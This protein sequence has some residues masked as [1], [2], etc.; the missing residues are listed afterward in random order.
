M[1]AKCLKLGPSSI[2]TKNAK[3]GTNTF[4]KVVSDE[5]SKTDAA[6]YMLKETKKQLEKK[7]PTVYDGTNQNLIPVPVQYDFGV[8]SSRGSQGANAKKKDQEV[9]RK[10]RA[11]A[12]Q[13]GDESLILQRIAQLEQLQKKKAEDEREK[14]HLELILR[15]KSPLS[16]EANVVLRFRTFF[17]NEPGLCLHSFSPSDYLLRYIELA[18]ELRK[19]FSPMK[20]LPLEK[21]ILRILQIPIGDIDKW[22]ADS[23]KKVEIK[24]PK[25]QSQRNPMFSGQ[26]ISD[27]LDLNGNC[28]KERKTQNVELMK[29]FATHHTQ[30]D[31]TVKRFV[32]VLDSKGKQKECYYSRKDIIHKLYKSEYD[33]LINSFHDEFDCLIF[34]PRY[35]LILGIEA[36]QAMTTNPESN[37]NQAKEA[38]K[39]V[40]KRES[41]I[42]KTFGDILS[43][44]WRYVRIVALYDHHGSAVTN[45]CPHCAPY[46]LTNGTESEQKQQM[47]DLMSAL[48]SNNRNGQPQSHSGMLEFQHVFSRLVG[49]SSLFMAVQKIDSY[50]N[51]M[52]TDATGISGGWTKAS[53]MKFGNDRDVSRLGDMIGRPHDIFKLIFFNQD[54][55]GLLALKHKCVIFLDDYGAG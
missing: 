45:K 55:I 26:L 8:N 27:A 54:Q 50:H 7:Y 39:Q 14:S 49:L 13:F 15:E 43:N 3:M 17:E 2:G 22:V 10:D 24:N 19:I 32:D 23:I 33:R 28:D 16:C 42:K 20:L 18:N 51:I 31:R 6:D 52:G 48:T 9:K 38:S 34:L 12:M 21:S 25:S 41:Y 47:K 37:D 53:K 30:W 11:R 44:G 29:T 40:K 4:D 5:F 1:A 36:K 35:R 46:I